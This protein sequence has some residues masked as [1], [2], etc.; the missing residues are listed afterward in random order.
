MT[1]VTGTVGSYVEDRSRAGRITP[2]WLGE[3]HS[4]DRTVTVRPPPET[5]GARYAKTDQS[6]PETRCEKSSGD[7]GEKK[8]ES[9][10]QRREKNGESRRQKSHESREKSGQN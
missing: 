5:Q 9:V 7:P 10:R 8:C 3:P 2:T 6:N 1:V 4:A